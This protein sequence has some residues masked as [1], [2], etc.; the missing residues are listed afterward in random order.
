MFSEK[1][2]LAA[3][4]GRPLRGSV[5]QP[6]EPTLDADE[7]GA[8]LLAVCLQPVAVDQPR[9]VVVGVVQDR[10]PQ[11]VAGGGI[12][13][14]GLPRSEADTAPKAVPQPGQHWENRSHDSG[15]CCGSLLRR[16]QQ[17]LTIIL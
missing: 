13:H 4:K 14:E 9:R 8:I 10:L 15:R 17:R 16:G 5:R 2:T 6:G 3:D 11:G 12:V 7:L 1:A